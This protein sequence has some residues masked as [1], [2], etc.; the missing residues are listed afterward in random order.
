M[1]QQPGLMGTLW[2]SGWH[3]RPG[4][5]PRRC[6][7]VLGAS[8]EPALKFVTFL[9]YDAC[10]W[11][12]ETAECSYTV[13]FWRLLREN[14]ISRV[15]QRQAKTRKAAAGPG[16]SD[17]GQRVW[18]PRPPPHLLAMLRGKLVSAVL[19]GAHG[20]ALTTEVLFSYACC[21]AA[22]SCSLHLGHGTVRLC[23]SRLH[24]PLL[25]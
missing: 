1:M 13:F 3:R 15:A 17:S 19:G 5:C 12:R 18:G 25:P 24:F 10:I 14:H 7:H 6:E 8:A 16:R 21:A 22:Q 4:S 2:E 20:R 11:W 23:H 9:S